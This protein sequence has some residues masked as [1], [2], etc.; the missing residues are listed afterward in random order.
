MFDFLGDFG[1]LFSGGG[2]SSKL[3]PLLGGA[4]VGVALA[5]RQKAMSMPQVATP[6]ALPQASKAPDASSV[7]T[8]LLGTGQAGGS[9][10]I[11]QTFLTGS[12][13]VDSKSLT[14]TKKQLLGS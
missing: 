2:D 6:D 14:T 11:A 12:G 13:G 1:D 5:S 3:L 10:G 7:L 4:L 8:S 9:P